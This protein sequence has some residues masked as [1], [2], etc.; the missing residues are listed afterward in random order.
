MFQ[1]MGMFNMNNDVNNELIVFQSTKL[2]RNVVNKL[3]LTVDYITRSGLK[4]VS[5]Y[6]KSPFMVYFLDADPASSFSLEAKVINSS[7]VRLYNFY[8]KVDKLHINHA[9][10]YQSS[11]KRYCKFPCRETSY[12]PDKK[13]WMRG[14]TTKPSWF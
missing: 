7:T 3:N 4:K 8:Q 6:T 5:L 12:S 13:I 10:C 1:D 2:M 9:P 11:C 14:T